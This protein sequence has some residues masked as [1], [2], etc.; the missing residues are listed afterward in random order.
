MLHHQRFLPFCS[1]IYLNCMCV[2][3]ENSFSMANVL[4]YGG[5]LMAIGS[6]SLLLH[7]GWKLFKGTPSAGNSCRG[8]G[9]YGMLVLMKR[10]LTSWSR[11]GFVGCVWR[12]RGAWSS[13]DSLPGEE[14]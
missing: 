1:F 10:C 7:Y 5:G 8:G 14:Q 11:R 9:M 6:T 13:G 2:L 4:H 12:L 3:F